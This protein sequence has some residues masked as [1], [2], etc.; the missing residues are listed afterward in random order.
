MVAIAIS[1]SRGDLY[2]YRPLATVTSL[3]MGPSFGFQ[4]GIEL[5]ISNFSERKWEWSL[6]TSRCVVLS[7][8]SGTELNSHT[9]TNQFGRF[10]LCAI[11]LLT[12]HDSRTILCDTNL[13]TKCN[14]ASVAPG[15]S[16][17]RRFYCQYPSFSYFEIRVS[18]C[19]I[20]KFKTHR[21]RGWLRSS[22]CSNDMIVAYTRTICT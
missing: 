14:A 17:W 11:H 5:D 1:L 8:N 13:A 10:H 4:T 3:R 22:R 18:W 19:W 7:A 21:L 12:S 6:P 20:L 15:I 2:S 16:R 9:M